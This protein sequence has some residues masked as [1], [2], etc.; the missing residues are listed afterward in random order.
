MSLEPTAPRLEPAFTADEERPI[1]GRPFLVPLYVPHFTARSLLVAVYV[2]VGL[3]EFPAA[4]VCDR[5]KSN[6]EISSTAIGRYFE[7]HLIGPCVTHTHKSRPVPG[8]LGD[9]GGD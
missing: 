8:I 2:W 9:Q 1:T 6:V 5:G 7:T 3:I 4:V